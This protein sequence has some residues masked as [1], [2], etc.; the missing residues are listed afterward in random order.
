V[1]DLGSGFNLIRNNT[2]TNLTIANLAHGNSGFDNSNPQGGLRYFC[3]GQTGNA[4]DMTVIK[5]YQAPIGA[6]IAEDQGDINQP[7]YNSFSYPLNG[8]YGIDWHLSNDASIL[9]KVNYWLPPNFNQSQ[10]PTDTFNVR[11]F[12]SITTG[13]PNFCDLQYTNLG[14]FKPLGSNGDIVDLLDLKAEYYQILGA[15]QQLLQAYQDNTT[16]TILPGEIGSKG[17]ELTDKANQVIFYYRNDTTANNCDSIAIWIQNKIGLYAEYELVEHYWGCQQYMTAI[18]HLATI[19]DNYVLSNIVLSNH[20]DYIA[21]LNLLYTAYQDNRTEAT[22]TKDE[23]ILLNELAENNNGFAAVKAANIVDF[24]YND[25]YRYHPTLPEGGKKKAQESLTKIQQGNLSI[26]PN[27][28]T[29]WADISYKLPENSNKGKLVVTST[30]GQQLLTLEL[31][32]QQGI[33]TLNTSNWFTG[34]YFVMLYAED[35]AVEQAQLII[36]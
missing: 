13:N 19:T 3:N 14:V 34:T 31:S 16:S 24:F 32:Q 21:L 36:R 20:Q 35:E 12:Q 7:A 33:L 28:T 2:F 1:D 29:T 27:P 22:L 30:S 6:A 5:A 11:T 26:Y 18:N 9:P 25:T 4:F 10:E 8:N 23:V 15:Y 17:Q